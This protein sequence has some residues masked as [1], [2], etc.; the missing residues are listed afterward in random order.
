MSS[1]DFFLTPNSICQIKIGVSNMKKSLNFYERVFGW[2]K[3]PVYI[4]DLSVLDVRGSGLG[5]ALVPDK[6]STGQRLTLYFSVSSEE[7]IETILEKAEKLTDSENYFER[8][9]V[10]SYGSVCYI[11]DPDRTRIGLFLKKD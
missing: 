7:L 11:F 9:Y 8:V 2:K 10:P 6:S 1:S 4:H 3:S 5:V